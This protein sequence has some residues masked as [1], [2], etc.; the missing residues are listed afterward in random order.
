VCF[1]ARELL[2]RR[3]GIHEPGQICLV[4]T[5][6]IGHWVFSALAVVALAAVLGVA[7]AASRVETLQVALGLGAGAAFAAV[8]IRRG[9]RRALL[10]A[11]ISFAGCALLGAREATFGFAGLFALWVHTAEASK[12]WVGLRAVTALVV[13]GCLGWPRYTPLVGDPTLPSWLWMAVLFV[14]ALALAKRK[15]LA[16]ARLRD[17]SGAAG[18]DSTH[19]ERDAVRD[20]V[21]LSLVPLAARG[22]LSSFESLVPSLLPLAPVVLLEVGLAFAPAESPPGAAPAA[23]GIAGR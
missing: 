12:R 8:W 19:A 2:R 21:I 23:R 7:I 3:I 20:I 6:R 15:R 18:I 11:T 10:L 13:A 4:R 5:M 14:V 9:D 16:G 17:E 1:D 22:E